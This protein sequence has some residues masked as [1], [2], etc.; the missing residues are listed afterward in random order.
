[1]IESENQTLH[2][3]LVNYTML[4]AKVVEYRCK[5]VRLSA[6]IESK[7]LLDKRHKSV[8]SAQAKAK[9]ERASVDGNIATIDEVR[10][11]CRRTLEYPLMPYEDRVELVC[12]YLE[13]V[14]SGLDDMFKPENQST[15][16]AA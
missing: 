8:A 4:I 2:R 6:V 5:M 3:H 9:A 1:M 16:G 15:D 11:M 14:V 10:E 13:S 7:E 12:R